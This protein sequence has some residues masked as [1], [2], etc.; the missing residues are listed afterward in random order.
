MRG[1]G[2][3][4]LTDAEGLLL[5]QRLLR[6]GQR[7]LRLLE[8]LAVL[9]GLLHSLALVVAR[10]VLELRGLGRCLLLLVQLCQQPRALRLRFGQ[11]ARHLLLL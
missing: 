6:L 4:P 10:L 1:C 7:D 11:L 8:P 3:G 2:G 5:V 9:L